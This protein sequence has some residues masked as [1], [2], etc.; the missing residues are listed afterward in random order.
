[1]AGLQRRFLSL[2]IALPVLMLLVSL[3][4]ACPFCSMQGPTLTGEVA[5]AKLVLYGQLANAKQSDTDTG[6]GTTDLIVQSLIKNELSG[7]KDDPLADNNKTVRLERYLQTAEGDKYRYLVYCDVFRGKIDP[8]RV[9][10]VKEGDMAKYLLG[11]LENKD[12]AIGKRLRFFFDYLDNPDLEISNDAYKEFS[13]ADYKDYKEMAKD[14]PPQRVAKWLKDEK[15]PAFR[16][17]LYASMLGHCG[18]EEHAKLLHDMLEDPAKRLGSGVDGMLAGY[19]MLKPKEGWAYTRDILKDGAKEFMVRYAALRAVRFLWDSRP[20][21]IE[22]KELSEGVGHLLDQSD[23][24][25]LAIDDLRKRQCWDMTERVLG[26]RNKKNPKGE[27]LADIPIVRRSILR[28]AL[29]SQDSKAKGGAAARTYVDEQRKK[30]PQMVADAEELLK[31]EQ[32][33][34][35][36]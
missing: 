13:N 10:P 35:S 9:V 32:T 2:G 31:L 3:A 18:K 24:A 23:I 28:F 20:D 8:Y 11:A 30:D 6:E 27:C 21:L 16:Y 22:P 15:T 5:Q 12:E 7:K 36:K 19:V 25:D 17:G 26:L 1:M 34:S 14:L 4:T 29:G 33:P